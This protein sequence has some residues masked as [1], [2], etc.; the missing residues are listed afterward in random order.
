MPW[1]KYESRYVCPCGSKWTVECCSKT[2]ELKM[3]SSSFRMVQFVLNEDQNPFIYWLIVNL[4]MFHYRSQRF[5]SGCWVLPMP[6]PNHQRVCYSEV[7]GGIAACSQCRSI[8]FIRLWPPLHAAK[9]EA[10]TFIPFSIYSTSITSFQSLNQLYPMW[11]LTSTIST[12][13]CLWPSACLTIPLLE[14]LN[15]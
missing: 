6:Y 1:L 2:P 3:L 11:W 9:C 10:V 14:D 15:V 8:G 12:W 5:V 7:I 13:R 4:K